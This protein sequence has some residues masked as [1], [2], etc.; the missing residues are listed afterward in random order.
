MLLSYILVERL[1]DGLVTAYQVARDSFVLCDASGVNF[2]DIRTRT[3]LTHPPNHWRDR[4]WVLCEDTPPDSI[5]TLPL[6]LFTICLPNSTTW[7]KKHNPDMFYMEP[8][9]WEEIVATRELC[10]VKGRERELAEFH[11]I[12]TKDGSKTPILGPRHNS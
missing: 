1:L 3:I 5:L 8:W 2:L 4:V 10:V 12:Y 9:S 6:V 11:A 7:R